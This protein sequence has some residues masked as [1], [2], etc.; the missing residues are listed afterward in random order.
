MKVSRR[1]T[2]NYDARQKDYQATKNH[3]EVKEEGAK[4]KILTEKTLGET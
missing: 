4:V 2:K 1:V 3:L